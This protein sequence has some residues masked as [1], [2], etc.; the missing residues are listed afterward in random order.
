MISS[1][2]GSTQ[3]INKEMKQN[4]DK[5]KYC[6]IPPVVDHHGQEVLLCCFKYYHK[7]WPTSTTSILIFVP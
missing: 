1:F 3:S 7:R 4:F 5:T 2:S 6:L